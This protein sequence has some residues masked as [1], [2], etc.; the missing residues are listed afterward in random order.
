ML[1]SVVTYGVARPAPHR[2]QRGGT[3]AARHGERCVRGEVF[4]LHAPRGAA[5]TSSPDP[6][7]S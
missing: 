4:R 1:I 7:T 2:H 3:C 6:A 5:A